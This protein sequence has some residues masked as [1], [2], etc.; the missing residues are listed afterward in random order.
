MPCFTALRKYCGFFFS[1]C[2]WACGILVPQQRI[3]PAL[4][5]QGLNQWTTW[6]VPGDIALFRLKVCGKFASDKSIDAIF[7]TAFAHSWSLCHTLVILPVFHTFSLFV[8]V[9]CD[10]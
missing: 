5:V 3:E 10:Q 1:P 8:I 2:C 4:E 7:P 9:I 6:G